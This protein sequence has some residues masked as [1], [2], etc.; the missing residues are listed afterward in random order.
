MENEFLANIQQEGEKFDFDSLVKS[1]EEPAEKPEKETPAESPPEVKPAEAPAPSAEEKPEEAAPEEDAKP[2]VFAAFHEHPR[3]KAR[4]KELKQ[5]RQKVDEYEEFKSRVDPLLSKLEKPTEQSQPPQ[6]FTSLF[7]NDEN[8]WNQYREA[9]MEERKAIRGEIMSELKPLFASV[10]QTKQQA[11]L[12]DWAQKQWTALESDPEV[13]KELQ[14]LGT[15]L[16]KIQGEISEIMSKYKPSDDDGNISLKASYELWKEMK[17]TSPQPNPIVAEKKKIG[18]ISK[19]KE[20]NEV[21]DFK[22]SADFRGKT[23]ADLID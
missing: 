21:R 22:T 2:E 12:V 8:V 4:E 9:S 20:D 11:E 16:S 13:K 6:W 10:E 14:G 5:L 23:I 1:E 3:W 15:N 19:S 7:G 17:K 18:A